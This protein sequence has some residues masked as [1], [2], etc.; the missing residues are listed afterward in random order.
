LKLALVLSIIKS[1]TERCKIKNLAF[2]FKQ[3]E[4]SIIKLRSH[5]S[6]AHLLHRLI[7]KREDS[8]SEMHHS[9]IHKEK[10]MEILRNIKS[11]LEKQ[12]IPHSQSAR[13]LFDG[14]SSQK[15]K[16]LD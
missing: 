8:M 2:S 11:S 5:G 1:A 7:K 4:I 6:E 16:I 3:I 12:R 13:P 9:Q 10:S 15:N 14:L